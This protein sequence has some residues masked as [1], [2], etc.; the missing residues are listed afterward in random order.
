MTAAIP[1]RCLPLPLA[2]SP[3]RAARGQ[4]VRAQAVQ[5]PK[6][7][8]EPPQEPVRPPRALIVPETSCCDVLRLPPTY[9]RQTEGGRTCKGHDF[10]KHG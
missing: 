5:A 6:G 4:R 10:V 7:V 1:T 8:T 2:P 9:V 3:A